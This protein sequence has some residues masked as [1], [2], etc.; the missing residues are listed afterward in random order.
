[1]SSTSDQSDLLLAHRYYSNTMSDEE[2]LS[3]ETRL[4]SDESAQQALIDVVQIEESL[5]AISQERPNGFVKPKQPANPSRQNYNVASTLALTAC[6]IVI[7]TIVVSRT[8]APL[9]PAI[10]QQPAADD[11]S[12]VSLWSQMSEPELT[13]NSQVAEVLDD[14]A[15]GQQSLELTV[16]DWMFVAVEV[17]SLEDDHDMVDP[18]SLDEETL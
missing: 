11:L 5:L 6:V 4:G 2:R 3:F 9:T 13:E 8:P 17:G 16:P 1:M 15:D 10:V 12:V 7:L 18:E 14:F